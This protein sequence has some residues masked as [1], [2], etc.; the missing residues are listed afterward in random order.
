MTINIELVHVDVNINEIHRIH[1]NNKLVV[2]FDVYVTV[3]NCI[4][5]TLENQID[6]ANPI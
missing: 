3:F 5:H 2:E 1:I 6:A 4:N